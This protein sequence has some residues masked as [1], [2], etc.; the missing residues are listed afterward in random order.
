MTSSR[1]PV[2][3]PIRTIFRANAFNSMADSIAETENQRREFV[4]NVSHELKTPMT[5]ISGFADG[6][7]DGT[8][9]PEKEKDALR[10]IS[11]ETRRLSRL[12]R[13][14]LDASRTEVR[15]QTLP[16]PSFPGSFLKIHRPDKEAVPDISDAH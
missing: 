16:I 8:V 4:A 5:T 2:S 9:P 3:S 11:N 10:V 13:R 7:L 1:V 6:I 12:V 15:Y 14:M